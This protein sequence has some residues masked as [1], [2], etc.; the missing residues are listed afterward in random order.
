MTQITDK[1]EEEQKREKGFTLIELMIVVAIIAILAAV[2]IPNFLRA[3]DRSRVSACLS[4]MVNLGT[5]AQDYIVE[6]GSLAGLG[7]W[8]DLCVHIYA[9]A[10]VPADCSGPLTDKVDAVCEPGSFN[11]ASTDYTFEFQASA[12]NN[13]SCFVCVTENMAVPED[14]DVPACPITAC[15]H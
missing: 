8:T 9:G 12:K 2:A 15:V 14:G 7:G 13:G 6:H 1:R 10:L 4:Q 5:A 11:F 3:R